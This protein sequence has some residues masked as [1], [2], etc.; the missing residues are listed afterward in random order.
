MLVGAAE[1]LVEAAELLEVFLDGLNV[2]EE[3]VEVDAGGGR[4]RGHLDDVVG[5]RSCFVASE[6]REGSGEEI[7]HLVGSLRW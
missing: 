4:R 2:L 7:V 5:R 3:L 6:A 1:G